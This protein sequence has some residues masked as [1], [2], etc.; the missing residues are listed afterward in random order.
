MSTKKSYYVL[1]NSLV[2]GNPVVVNGPFNSKKEALKECGP[3]E[4]VELLTQSQAKE[5]TC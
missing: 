1:T 4:W 2:N 3:D 5:L